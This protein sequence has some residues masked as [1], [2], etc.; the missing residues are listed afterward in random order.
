ME[1]RCQS[2]GN[3]NSGFLLPLWSKTTFKLDLGGEIK[4]LHLSPLESLEDKL[5]DNNVKKEITCKEC[6]N[7]E[8]EIVLNE[9]ENNSSISSEQNALEGL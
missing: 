6:G 4:I 1:I 9:F 3:Q 2:C 7:C 5:T 8:V